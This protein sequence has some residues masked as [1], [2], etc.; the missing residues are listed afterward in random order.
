MPDLLLLVQ[1]FLKLRLP[2]PALLLGVF[3]VIAHISHKL[4]HLDL[5]DLGDDAVKEIP[6]MGYD[7]HGARIV[8]KIGFK[9]GDGV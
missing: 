8:Q 4:P 9:P 5:Q 1:I 7:Q 6:V 3:A 2:E